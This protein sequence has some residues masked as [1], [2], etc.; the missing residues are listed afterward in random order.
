MRGV[1]AGLFIAVAMQSTCSAVAQSYPSPPLRVVVGAS[2]GGAGDVMARVVSGGFTPL[3]GQQVTI[4][5]RPGAASNS[6]AEI[7]AKSPADGHAVF[8]VSITHAVN[9]CLYPNLPF[10]LRR[11]FSA[12]MQLAS[13]P[14]V[15]VVRPSLSSKHRR[16]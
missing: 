16:I 6:A 3:L 11:D 1:C 12:V 13:S 4:D 7:V 2:A 14:R 5:N 9:V 15:I 10:D 8:M